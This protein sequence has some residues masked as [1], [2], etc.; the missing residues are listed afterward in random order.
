MF[1]LR[2][3]LLPR[4]KQTRNIE[5]SSLGLQRSGIKVSRLILPPFVLQNLLSLDIVY[6]CCA[7]S[8]NSS[9]DIFTCPVDNIDPTKVGSWSSLQLLHRNLPTRKPHDLLKGR[10]F[11][12]G[13]RS[14]LGSEHFFGRN[15]WCLEV[16]WPS[17]SI[18]ECLGGDLLWATSMYFRGRSE[19]RRQI[20]ALKQWNHVC[21]WY[22]NAAILS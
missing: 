21:V 3:K 15:P 17:P 13:L 12:E 1:C 7:L 22:Q 10:V 2:F 8:G 14:H 4:E 16:G 6:C 9:I 18:I 11:I 5:D 20:A 19:F